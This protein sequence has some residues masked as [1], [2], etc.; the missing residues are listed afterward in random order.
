[1]SPEKAIVLPQSLIDIIRVKNPTE[2]EIEAV[3]KSRTHDVESATMMGRNV[4]G[5][6]DT[7]SI[8]PIPEYMV[9]N[10]FNQDTSTDL[11]YKRLRDIQHDSPMWDHVLEF[12]RS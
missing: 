11:V 6:E 10:G 2:S 8:T 9:Y 12:L 3:F 7:M 4:S 5:K 1:M